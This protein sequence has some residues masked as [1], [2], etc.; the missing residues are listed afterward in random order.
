MRRMYSVKP[1]ADLRCRLGKT[2]PVFY[3]QFETD[4]IAF[5]ESHVEI[6]SIK[7]LTEF[8]LHCAQHLVPDRAAN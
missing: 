7:N 3:F 6:G 2:W 8:F 4:L 5:L 1:L